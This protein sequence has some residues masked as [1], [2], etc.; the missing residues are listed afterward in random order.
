MIS[1]ISSLFGK[2]LLIA[3]GLATEANAWA[4]FDDLE[5]TL[6]PGARAFCHVMRFPQGW[7]FARFDKEVGQR[8][9]FGSPGSDYEFRVEGV[10]STKFLV[11]G[12]TGFVGT[13]YYTSNR[14]KVDLS[15]AMAPVLVV[16]RKAWDAAAVVPL[17]RKSAFPSGT[18]FPN[19]MRLEFHVGAGEV[20]NVGVFKG[21][22]SDAMPFA[23]NAFRQTGELIGLNSDQKKRS[24]SVLALEH[25]ENFGSPFRVWA[26]IESK[27]HLVW[28]IAIATHAIRFR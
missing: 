8:L 11:E 14:Y 23:V 4:Q 13:N 27:C 22:V 15:D 19:E 10:L 17:A 26:I 18:T 1:R 5:V 20:A 28:A 7:A 21:M 25:V 16:D 12:F 3:V 9:F 6:A 2:S 24:R